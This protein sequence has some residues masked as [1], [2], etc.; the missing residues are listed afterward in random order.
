MN[1]TN[2][3]KQ[4]TLLYMGEDLREDVIK[5]ILNIRTK[6]NAHTP[7]AF[8]NTRTNNFEPRQE[9][10]EKGDLKDFI[11]YFSQLPKEC[12]ET[13]VCDLL[14]KYKE[15]FKGVYKYNFCKFEMGRIILHYCRECETENVELIGALQKLKNG[16]D[17]KI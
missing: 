15:T 10:T 11:L 9:C 4:A 3:I 14:K 1:R 13:C 5:A 6:C 8:Y 7:F 2:Q 12:T 16:E 17:F